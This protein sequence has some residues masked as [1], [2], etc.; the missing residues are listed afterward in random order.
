M[1]TDKVGANIG[2]EFMSS[3]LILSEIGGKVINLR[4]RVDCSCWGFEERQPSGRGH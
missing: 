2:G 4:M 3:A 1:G